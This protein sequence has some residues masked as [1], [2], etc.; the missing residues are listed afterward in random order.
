MLF[1]S[2]RKIASALSISILCYMNISLTLMW[3]C[4]PLIPAVGH[5][6]GWI[7]EMSSRPVRST[8]SVRVKRL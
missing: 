5:R 4:I 7:S 8:L 2:K 1:F 6:G 3:C